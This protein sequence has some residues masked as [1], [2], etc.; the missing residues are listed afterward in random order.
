LVVRDAML[1]ADVAEH[2]VHLSTDGNGNL[3]AGHGVQ[4]YHPLVRPDHESGGDRQRVTRLVHE[5]DH[6]MGV[7]AGLQTLQQIDR[8][9]HR[10]ASASS[11]TWGGRLVSPSSHRK[12]RRGLTTMT[13]RSKNRG[14]ATRLPRKKSMAGSF[15]R[16]IGSTRSHPA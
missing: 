4:G 8:G 6:G 15:F 3:L 13:P 2:H 5:G 1:G 12:A 10:A 7:A 9:A 11:K 14:R 16:Q